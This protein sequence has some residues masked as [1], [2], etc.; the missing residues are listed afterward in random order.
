[1]ILCER[2]NFLTAALSFEPPTLGIY[3][4]SSNSFMET[5]L[6]WICKM[7][8]LQTVA[9]NFNFLPTILNFCSGNYSRKELF[10]GQKY[11][12]EYGSQRSSCFAMLMLLMCCIC[13][14]QVWILF[15]FIRI[16]LYKLFC[17]I[18]CMA[19]TSTDSSSKLGTTLVLRTCFGQRKKKG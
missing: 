2:H 16:L 7:N 1:M 9:T 12:W 19:T 10:K 6:S 13:C 4:I 3:R 5:I 8:E 17:P 15:E 14:F 11:S 18:V